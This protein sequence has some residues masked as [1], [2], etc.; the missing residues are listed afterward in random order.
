MPPAP[1]LPNPLPRSPLPLQVRSSTAASKREFL[2]RKG[3]TEAEIDEAFR[4]VPQQPASAP[5]VPVAAAPGAAAP[6][7]VAGTLQHLQPGQ[8]A[9]QTAYM[10]PQ[11]GPLVYAQQPQ[12]MQQQQQ[13]GYGPGAMVVAPP[14]QQGVRWTQVSGLLGGGGELPAQ[15]TPHSA[16]THIPMWQLAKRI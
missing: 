16:P 1:P 2:Q 4:R 12:G 14:Q 15:Y 6:A 13:P 7:A 9:Q 10:Q 8:P 11:Q 5:S 3:L